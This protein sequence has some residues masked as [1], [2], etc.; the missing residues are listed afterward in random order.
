MKRASFIRNAEGASALEFALL[1]PVFFALFA[2]IIEAGLLMWTQVALQKGVEAAA[3]CASV[4]STLC[5]STAQVKAYASAQSVGVVPPASTF[6]LTTATC[7]SQVTASYPYT[8][9]F[10]YFTTAVTLKAGSC[11]PK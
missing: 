9:L 7:G 8:F 4:N 2:G 11:F 10:G 5:G 6:T 1:A 3:R